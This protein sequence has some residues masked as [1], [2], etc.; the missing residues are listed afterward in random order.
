MEIYADYSFYA[1]NWSGRTPEE[2][3]NFLAR[4]AVNFINYVTFDRLTALPVIDERVKLC[5][6]ELIDYLYEQHAIE[7]AASEGRGMIASEKVDNYS[8]SYMASNKSTTINYNT[9]REKE[10]K[11]TTICRKWLEPTGHMSL[12]VY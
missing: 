3:Y 1:E 8:V 6:C 10:D 9:G 12:A 7:E 5:Q 2:I 4:Q 11:S